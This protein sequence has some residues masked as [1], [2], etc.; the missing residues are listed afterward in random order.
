MCM[1][2]KNAWEL[3]QINQIH[4]VKKKHFPVL[5]IAIYQH[6]YYNLHLYVI[7]QRKYSL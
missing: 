3:D 2:G 5:F 1:I 4:I 7:V 6:V